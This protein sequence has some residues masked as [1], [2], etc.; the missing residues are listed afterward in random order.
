M[1]RRWVWSSITTKRRKQRPEA[2]RGRMGLMQVNMRSR[3]KAMSSSS[4]NWT[5]ASMRRDPSAAEAGEFLGGMMARLKSCPS[6]SVMVDGVSLAP[7]SITSSARAKM[8]GLLGTT[9]RLWGESQRVQRDHWRRR[10]STGRSRPWRARESA[11]IRV[12]A[13]IFGLLQTGL[14]ASASAFGLRASGF[15]FETITFEGLFLLLLCHSPLSFNRGRAGVTITA[16]QFQQRL[17]ASGFWI[18]KL[19]L[20]AFFLC[21]RGRR[22]T[23]GLAPSGKCFLSSLAILKSTPFPRERF[24]KRTIGLQ[25]YSRLLCLSR[26]KHHRLYPQQ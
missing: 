15:G 1:V 18:E 19:G 13:S 23:S 16:L 4:E 26:E 9:K 7:M 11:T 20:S 8:P 21:L 22:V 3:V 14:R 12:R 24:Q 2:R 10:G 6:R 17:S 25:S 5:T